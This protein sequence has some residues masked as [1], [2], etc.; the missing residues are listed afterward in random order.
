[1]DQPGKVAN[2]ARDELNR[3]NDFFPVPGRAFEFGLETGS[4]VPSR[5]I[6]LILHTQAE[7]SNL[8]LIRGIPPAFRDGV[9]VHLFIQSSA[10]GSVPSLSSHAVAFSKNGLGS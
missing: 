2:P 5:V 9:I 3:G 1:M 10:I 7:S 8:V 4:V 6:L